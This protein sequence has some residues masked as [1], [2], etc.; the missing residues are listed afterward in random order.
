MGKDLTCLNS[1]IMQ[2]EKLM[3]TKMMIM[4]AI[5]S[6]VVISPVLSSE[7]SAS[8]TTN[9]HESKSEKHDSLK[10]DPAVEHTTKASKSDWEEAETALL[11]SDYA[12]AKQMYKRF[13]EA[14]KNNAMAWLRLGTCC[15]A[16]EEWKEALAAFQ[17]AYELDPKG[18][19]QILYFMATVHDKLNEHSKAAEEYRKYIDLDYNGNFWKAAKSRLREIETS[20]STSDASK[21]QP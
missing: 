6:Q 16:L 21:V 8:N 14:D 1:L 15:R 9:L 12:A 19:K 3:L 2:M 18:Q 4:A 10:S 13:V 17:R 5:V 20:E 7:T 11:K